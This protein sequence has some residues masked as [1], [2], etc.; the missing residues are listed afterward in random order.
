MGTCPS[1]ICRERGIYFS[2][3][4]LPEHSIGKRNEME[5]P[6][7]TEIIYPSGHRQLWRSHYLPFN[8][9]DIYECVTLSPDGDNLELRILSSK[10]F[11]RTL[12]RAQR[13]GAK[14]R[15][16]KQVIPKEF[17]DF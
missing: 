12:K 2:L 15:Q 13:M 4:C 17:Q 14:I 1:Y 6:I 16:T 5:N 10:Q 3:R 9:T 7:T 11:Q 8:D